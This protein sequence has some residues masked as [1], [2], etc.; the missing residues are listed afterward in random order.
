M[1][2][3]SLKLNRKFILTLIPLAFLLNAFTQKAGIFDGRNDVGD[4]LHAGTV[5][6][7]KDD[8]QYELSGSGAN[9]CRSRI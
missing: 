2:K 4:V 8:Q 3:P 5:S 1:M 6:Y 7:N 9:H